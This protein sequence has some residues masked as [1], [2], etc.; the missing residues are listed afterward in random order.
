MQ[1]LVDRSPCFRARREFSV[2]K[3]HLGDL[4]RV[5]ELQRVVFFKL[6]RFASPQFKIQFN[7]SMPF[8]LI[9]PEESEKHEL[10]PEAAFDDGNRNWR[11]ATPS[12]API[13]SPKS[14]LES[15]YEGISTLD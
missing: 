15:D 7:Q 8:H 14:S 4:S 12:T 2:G 1:G 6:L 10:V 9:W 3:A 5:T 11:N 13:V